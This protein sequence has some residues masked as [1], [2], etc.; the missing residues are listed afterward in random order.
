MPNHE[1]SRDYVTWAAY[2]KLGADSLNRKLCLQ[3]QSIS[4]FYDEMA[5]TSLTPTLLALPL[6]PQS[7]LTA[8][9][10]SFDQLIEKEKTQS[11]FTD[12]SAQR[13]STNQN[14]CSIA[15]LHW[16]SSSLFDCSLCTRRWTK[17]CTYIDL[18][19][20]VNSWARWSGTWKKQYWETPDREVWERSMKM[21]LSER[22]QS[23]KIFVSHV[24]GHQKTSIAVEVL[25]NQENKLTWRVDVTRSVPNHP[26]AYSMG[27]CTTWPWWPEWRLLLT[28][29]DLASTLVECLICQ[30]Q[31]LMLSP[32]M[33]KYSP[34]GPDSYLVQIDYIGL[35][36]TWRR[37]G[38]ILIEINCIWTWIGLSYL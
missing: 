35:F 17:V 9:V 23:V 31:R 2:N 6:F 22:A 28:K 13:A 19:A 16:N 12:V 18:G 27:P 11:W 5:Q 7:T 29:A 14:G 8:P 38:L 34:E 1:I 26:S 10:S 33:C 32:L 15:I 25:S 37:H 20:I 4:K 3:Q 30:H 24:T 36:P 21:N